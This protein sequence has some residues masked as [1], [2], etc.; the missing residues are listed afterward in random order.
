MPVLD[1]FKQYGTLLG[2]KRHDE[3]V[4][5]DEQPAS[6]NLLEFYFKRAFDFGDFQRTEQFRGVGIEGSKPSF[7]TMSMRSETAH[8]L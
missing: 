4:V 1:D 8:S 6:L 3:Q 7:A 5:K 2:I